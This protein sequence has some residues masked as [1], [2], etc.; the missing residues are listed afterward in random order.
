MTF[1][2][3]GCKEATDEKILFYGTPTNEGEAR[4]AVHIYDK[5]GIEVNAG[6]SRTIFFEYVLQ[7]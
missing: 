4:I 6:Y 5:D 7:E 3:Q 1:T 2:M